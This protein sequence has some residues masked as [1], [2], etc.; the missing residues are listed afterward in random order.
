MVQGQKPIHAMSMILAGLLYPGV[1]YPDNGQ[2][3]SYEHREGHYRVGACWFGG[4]PWWP[5]RKMKR[6]LPTA[7]GSAIMEMISQRLQASL[8]PTTTMQIV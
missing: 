8:C 2:I 3:I 7:K 1:G 6:G 4:W 5:K